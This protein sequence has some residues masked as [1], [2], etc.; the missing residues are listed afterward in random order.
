MKAKE[1]ANHITG[2]LKDYCDN[3]KLSGFVV[4]ISG[5]V[6]SALTSTLAAM[7]GKKVILLSMPIRQTSAEYN[8]A[9][10]HGSDLKSRFKNVELHEIDL[11]STFAEFEKQMPFSIENEQLSMANSRARL[12]MTTLYAVAQ[13]NHCLVAGTGNKIEDFGIGFRSD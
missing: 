3:S 12:R 1:I 5:G 7:T 13:A 11:T 9:K 2:W 8:R 6:D 10:N 4:G